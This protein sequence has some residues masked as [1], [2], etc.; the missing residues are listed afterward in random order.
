LLAEISIFI[1]V[2]QSSYIN[3]KNFKI[4]WQKWEKRE[5][6]FEKRQ[7]WNMMF[8]QLPLKVAPELPDFGFAMEKEKAN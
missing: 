7:K 5:L 4:G 3:I 8:T 1:F 2:E 6:G